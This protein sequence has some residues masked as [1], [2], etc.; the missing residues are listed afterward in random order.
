L[1]V[2]YLHDHGVVHR[3][4][5]LDNILLTDRGHLK[6][7]DFGM[8]TPSNSLA[9]RRSDRPAGGEDTGS[10]VESL[11]FTANGGSMRSEEA[12]SSA[13]FRYHDYHGQLR[14]VVGNY[15]YAAPE[16]VLELGYDH[17]I[18]WWSCG[19]LFFQFLSG[20]TPFMASTAER[21]V[22]N[23]AEYRFNWKALPAETSNGA[24]TMLSGL[25]AYQA[26]DRLGSNRSEDVLRHAYFSDV[27]FANI[28][29]QQGPLMPVELS[30]EGK[31]KRAKAVAAG[32]EY[33]FPVFL[34]DAMEYKNDEFESFT[35]DNYSVSSK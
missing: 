4:I 27:D 25:L 21:T 10:W 16:V 33:V 35:L 6:L 28:Y 14:S 29:N 12:A 30:T 2:A 9:S 26:K 32:K 13:S 24:R 34:N 1:A 22:D 8:V 17:A 7:M 23:I 3:D 5:K 20:T 31:D 11:S 19:I 18:D 15:H